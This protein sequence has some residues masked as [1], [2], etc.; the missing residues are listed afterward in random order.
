[1]GK[2]RPSLHPDNLTVSRIHVVLRPFETKLNALAR[3]LERRVAKDTFAPKSRQPGVTYAKRHRIRAMTGMSS[4]QAGRAYV[5]EKKKGLS[6]LYSF[7]EQ[8]IGVEDAF[9]N[10]VKGIPTPDQQ[11]IPTLRGIIAKKVGEQ[12]AEETMRDKEE[13]EAEG[14]VDCIGLWYGE[15]PVYARK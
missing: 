4:R 9:S 10:L 13:L 12:V 6:T 5:L 8:V 15:L 1:M 14:I 7:H 3:T 11:R 2:T